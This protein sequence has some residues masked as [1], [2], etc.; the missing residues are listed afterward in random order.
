MRKLR[1]DLDQLAVDGFT[2]GEAHG[3]GTIRAR[4]DAFAIEDG[5]FAITPPPTEWKTCQTC[6]GQ[7]T[8]YI[9]CVTNCTCQTIPGCTTCT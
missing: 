9:S 5:D 8:C 4:I 3:I 7:D 1:L 2:T 6:Q